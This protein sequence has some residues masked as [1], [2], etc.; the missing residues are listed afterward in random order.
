MF[1]LGTIFHSVLGCLFAFLAYK[2]PRKFAY[3][4]LVSLGFMLKE[5]GEAKYKI[6]GS[7]KTLEKNIAMLK[8]VFVPEIVI[9][10]ALPGLVVFAFIWWLEKKD[11]AN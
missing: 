3:G 1:A 6:P 2:L 7:I 9:Q 10:W 8:S 4:L 5:L 11:G